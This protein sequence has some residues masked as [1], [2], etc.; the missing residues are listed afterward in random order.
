M[1]YVYIFIVVIIL[2]RIDILIH[3][4]ETLIS[5][6]KKT[7]V[8]TE[9]LPS[10]DPQTNN[11]IP[12][13]EDKS[14]NQGPKST[15]YILLDD[16]HINPIKSVREQLIEVLR[17]NPSI[18][19][20]KLDPVFE[21]EIF[22]LT[23]LIYNKNTELPYLL[24]DFLEIL[25]G[26]NLEMVKRFFTIMMDND[27]ERFLKA[28]SRGKDTNCMIA[29]LLG[30]RVPEEELVFEYREREEKLTQFLTG[31]KIDPAISGLAKKCLLVLQLHLNKLAPEPT[32]EEKAAQAEAAAVDPAVAPTPTPTPAEAGAVPPA[33]SVQP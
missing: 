4:V 32:A 12:F 28:Y 25:Q 22:K 29:N 33:Q 13:T 20:I 24:L 11:I 1:K 18:V 10:S 31:E 14:I 30:H 17:K 8:Q 7:N 16:F 3:G 15:F 6:A 19:G 26:E 9:A 27:L 2:V 23:D 5:K 21:G